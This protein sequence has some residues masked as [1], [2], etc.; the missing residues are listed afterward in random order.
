MVPRRRTARHFQLESLD[1]RDVPAPPIVVGAGG[2]LVNVAANVSNVLN[3]NNVD[4][5]V[6]VSHN[7]IQVGVLSAL[8]QL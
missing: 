5:P 8:Q 3:N 7:N 4:V 6:T 2:G 1:R